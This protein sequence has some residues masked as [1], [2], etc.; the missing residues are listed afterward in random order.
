M[1]QYKKKS[2]AQSFNS[3]RVHEGIKRINTRKKEDEEIFWPSD[4]E[5]KRFYC[6]LSDFSAKRKDKLNLNIR[7]VH[8]GLDKTCEHC[9]YS[10]G[11]NQHLWRHIRSKHPN[12][13][14]LQVEMLKCTE[15][16]EECN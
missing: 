5:G 13:E 4:H 8:E 9:D 3:F 6:E 7:V 11:T 2:L 12:V 10:A 1:Y 14:D 16:D 15:C